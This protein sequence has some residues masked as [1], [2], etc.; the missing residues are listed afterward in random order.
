VRRH[1]QA[2]SHLVVATRNRLLVPRHAL[3]ER[4]DGGGVLRSRAS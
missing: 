1:T 3:L 2:H 4:V